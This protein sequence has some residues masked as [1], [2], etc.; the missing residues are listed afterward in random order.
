MSEMISAKGGVYGRIM[1]TATNWIQH[2]STETVNV[3]R[4]GEK[5]AVSRETKGSRWLAGEKPKASRENEAAMTRQNCMRGGSRSRL[6]VSTMMSR[7]QQAAITKYKAA[8]TIALAQNIS[9]FMQLS[10]SPSTPPP[11]G[12]SLPLPE[13]PLPLVAPLADAAHERRWCK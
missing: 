7:V 5:N 9:A 1:S 12:P 3:K 6:C 8:T 4:A 11:S 10:R 13:E 2:W